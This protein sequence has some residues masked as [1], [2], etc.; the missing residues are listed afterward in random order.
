MSDN[1]EC[2]CALCALEGSELQVS[3]FVVRMRQ[4]KYPVVSYHGPA[5]SALDNTRLI[6]LAV[7]AHTGKLTDDDNDRLEIGDT[8]KLGGD[9]R[10]FTSMIERRGRF[11]YKVSFHDKLQRDTQSATQ[12]A[13]QSSEESEDAFFSCDEDAPP[14]YDDDNDLP[15]VYSETAFLHRRIAEQIPNPKG[16]KYI[17]HINGNKLDNRVQNLRWVSRGGDEGIYPD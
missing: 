17:L 5:I 16:Y 4:R 1:T 10:S 13:T 14:S 2:D 15:P 9:G 8:W 7:D 12:S 11:I 6:R 3:N